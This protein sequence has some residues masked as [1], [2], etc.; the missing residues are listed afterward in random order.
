MYID[1]EKALIKSMQ[2]L[3]NVVIN[4]LVERLLFNDYFT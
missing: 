2:Q 4:V 1:K 3:L